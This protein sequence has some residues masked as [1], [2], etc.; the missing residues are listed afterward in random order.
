M[1][2]LRQEGE[3]PGNTGKGRRGS[4]KPWESWNQAGV[5]VTRAP[6]LGLD[7]KTEEAKATRQG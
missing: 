3:P 7:R 4:R 5:K 6:P 2:A 1:V